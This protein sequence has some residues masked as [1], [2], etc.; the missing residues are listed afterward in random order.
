MS[1][2]L[3]VSRSRQQAG[4]EP[5]L[6]HTIPDRYFVV[7]NDELVRVSHLLLFTQQPRYVAAA[8]LEKTIFLNCPFVK[9]LILTSSQGSEGSQALPIVCGK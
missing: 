6:Q 5:S 9:M 7:T 3:S 1:D 8:N 4:G 2:S